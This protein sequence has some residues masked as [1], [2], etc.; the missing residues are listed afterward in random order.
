MD[1]RLYSTWIQCCQGLN[2]LICKG[3]MFNTENHS[4]Q[5][6]S[7]LLV[8]SFLCKSV[9][10]VCVGLCWFGFFVCFHL[11]LKCTKVLHSSPCFQDSP[12]VCFV[13]NTSISSITFLSLLNKSP[14]LADADWEVIIKR[15]SYPEHTGYAPDYRVPTKSAWVV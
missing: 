4:L 11:I 2:S 5:C 12:Q 8:I 10:R 6:H 14:G 15:F 9:C 3:R 1:A 13:T 7:F